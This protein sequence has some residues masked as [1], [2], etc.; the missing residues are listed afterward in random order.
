MHITWLSTPI[1]RNAGRTDAILGIDE[2]GTWFVRLNEPVPADSNQGAMFLLPLMQDGYGGTLQTARGR[3]IAALSDA[4]LPVS[5]EST[6]PYHAPVMIAFRSMPR[7]TN[8]A[9]RWLSE[10]ELS[11]DDIYAVFVACSN[12]TIAQD[13]R[14]TALRKVHEWE[15]THGYSFVR[16][17]NSTGA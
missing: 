9:A 12:P 8:W 10:L 11:D 1:F 3:I 2:F 4:S 16:P 6:F 14:H 13:A 17:K 15:R 5:R 7:W